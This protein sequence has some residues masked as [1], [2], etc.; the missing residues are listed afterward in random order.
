MARVGNVD[1]CNQAIIEVGGNLIND[2]GENSREGEITEQIFVPTRDA[3]IEKADW[4]F[5]T[6]RAT[7]SATGTPPEHGYE[8]QFNAP[9]ESARIIN[10]SSDPKAEINNVDWRLE[11][12]KILANEKLIY[13]KYLTD[14][15]TDLSEWS[16][17]GRQALVYALAAKMAIPIARSRTLKTDLEVISER[18]FEDSKTSDGLQGRSEKIRGNRFKRA[19]YRDGGGRVGPYV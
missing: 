19:R 16:E 11:G 12:N 14:K 8:N 1:V 6:K 4:T 3:L 5:A 17:E 10:V 15:A 18:K 7:L 9:P 13:V 2:I